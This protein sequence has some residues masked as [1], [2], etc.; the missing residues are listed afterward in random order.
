MSGKTAKTFK[1][2]DLA[3]VEQD[4][5]VVDEES[6]S[7]SSEDERHRLA[8]STSINDGE[9]DYPEN[10]SGSFMIP[11]CESLNLSSN[12]MAVSAND[13]TFPNSNRDEIF[14]QSRTQSERASQTIHSLSTFGQ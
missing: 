8:K 3:A 5:V 9:E 14:D 6:S 2:S 13:G 7:S 11:R 4:P 1:Y 12:K 10:D